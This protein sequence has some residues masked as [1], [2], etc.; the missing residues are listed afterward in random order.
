ME[1]SKR[2][3]R[4]AHQAGLRVGAYIG[5][6]LL[7]ER[8]FDEEPEARDWR[9]LSG[10]GKK[11]VFYPGQE[12]RYTAVRSHPGYIQYIKKPVRFAVEEVQADMIHF[13]NFGWA[14]SYND[15]FSKRQFAAYLQSRGK[16]PGGPDYWKNWKDCN[17][18]SLA[19]FYVEMSRYVRSLNPRCA[20]E[21]NPAGAIGNVESGIDH[22][23]LLPE[24]NAFW[25]E[26][27]GAGPAQIRAM[28]VGELY[29]NSTF[30]YCRTALDLAE[31]MTFNVN[32]LG[33][34]A[35]FEWGKVTKPNVD[36]AKPVAKDELKPYIRFF[37]DH[38]DLY[39]HWPSVADVAVLWTFAEEAL[40]EKKDKDIVRNV[41]RALIQGHT[42]WRIIFDEHLDQL[43]GYRVL[44]VPDKQ[45][46]T[47]EQEQKITRFAQQGGLVVR[48]RDVSSPDA[49]PKTVSDRLRA[50]VDAPPSVAMELRQQ[51]KP[52][53]VIVHLVNYNYDPRRPV[54]NVAVKLRVK[55]G[56][57]QSVRLVSPDPFTSMT[58][59]FESTPRGCSFVV[60]ELKIY[61]AVVI[62]GIGI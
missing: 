25:V 48:A 19:D 12:F 35:W 56:T 58:L 32:C 15:P 30:V 43:A 33:C 55:T 40:A 18:Q 23:R 3:A 27:G 6:T 9:C 34:V 57:P 14:V 54:Q 45:W 50:V 37:L 5:G 7:F 53:Q 61:G 28:K 47:A 21:C 60:P 26:G 16:T 41:E 1:D 29:N 46:L 59:P 52:Q 36:G 20:V 10:S 31:S 2:F 38:Q 17:C 4:L 49:F 44:V 51:S 62:D 24:G 39:R 11:P 42:A 13:D 8:L 22:A